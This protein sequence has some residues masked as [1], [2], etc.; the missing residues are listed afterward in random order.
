MLTSFGCVANMY[1]IMLSSGLQIQVASS[2][3]IPI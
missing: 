1:I 3:S 2:P